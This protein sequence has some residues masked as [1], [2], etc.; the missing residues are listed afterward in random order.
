[1]SNRQHDS[2]G[3]KWNIFTTATTAAA[4]ATTIIAIII[5]RWNAKILDGYIDFII[6]PLPVH[7]IGFPK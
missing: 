6:R 2:K 3:F 5:L 7:K 4:A 1:M